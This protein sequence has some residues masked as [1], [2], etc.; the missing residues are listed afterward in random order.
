MG[1]GSESTNGSARTLRNIGWRYLLRH[2][3][4]SVLMVVGIML[5]V[6]VVVSIDLANESA[7]RAFDLS[8]ESV[9]GR[10]T[11]EIVGGPQGL[12]EAIYTWLRRS[13]LANAEDAGHRA[14]RHRHGGLAAAWR[15]QCACWG[16]PFA[17]APFRRYLAGRATP[18]RGDHGVHDRAGRGAD[19]DR[20]GGRFGLEMGTRSRWRSPG[21]GGR[22]RR[23]LLE[24]S[25]DLSRRSLNGLIL[26]DVATA[27]EVLRAPACW[28]ASTCCCPKATRRQPNASRRCR[29]VCLQPVAARTGTVGR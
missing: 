7:S 4:Q 18:D 16:G 24:P 8:V 11:H 15:P 5:G 26:A 17:E 14:H 1:R 12:D 19:L 20:R 3:W 22:C 2:P 9:A 6:A 13:G 21:A 25:D 23:G 10:A 29:R 28:I 27:Q